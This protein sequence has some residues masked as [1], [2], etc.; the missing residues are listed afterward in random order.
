MKTVRTLLCVALAASLAACQP[1]APDA[2]GAAA[3][4]E[5][6]GL[7]GRNVEAA[8]EKGRKK[9]ATEN[10]T[11]NNDG[12]G[13]AEITPQGD[14][15]IEGKAVALDDEQRR[16]LLAYRGEVSAIASAGMDVGTEGA[17]LASKAVA[18]AIGGIFSGKP[19]DIE[20]RIEAQAQGIKTK[21]RALCD[22]LPRLYEAQQR[23]AAGVPDF[24]P[25]ARMTPDDIDDCR[26]DVENDIPGEATSE[27]QVAASV[28]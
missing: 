20:A 27:A 28:E 11:I 25:Y 10:I 26:R 24:A 3:S 6:S 8:M 18:E 21:A 19:E 23:V 5:D 2:A 22:R 12:Q 13:K 1:K 9:L 4:Q 14:L 16:L 17:K 7:I 15:L